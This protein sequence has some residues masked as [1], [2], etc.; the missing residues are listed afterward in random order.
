MM[1]SDIVWAIVMGSIIGAVSGVV[2]YLTERMV[3]LCRW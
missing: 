3:T 1:K 2:L